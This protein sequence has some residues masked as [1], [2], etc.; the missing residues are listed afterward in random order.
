MNN[1]VIGNIVMSLSVI[2][3]IITMQQN[4]K[5]KILIGLILENLISAIGFVFLTSYSAVVV[6]S[7]AIAQTYIK[8][9]YDLKNKKLSNVFQVAF[10][11]L[12]IAMG[13]LT[14]KTLFDVLPMICLVL[15]TLSILQSKEKNIRLFTIVNILGW[16]IYDY[17]AKSY[18]G[19]AFN[20]F[21]FISTIIAIYRYD[22]KKKEEK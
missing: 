8:Y 11:I 21:T 22:M 3:K 4:D 18:I 10:I 20:I 13:I 19:F 17:Y 12:A 1:I 15:Y 16:I 6:T 5:K 14:I 2:V 9:R 7:L